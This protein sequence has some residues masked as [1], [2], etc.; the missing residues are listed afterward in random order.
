MAKKFVK[1]NAELNFFQRIYR[2]YWFILPISFIIVVLLT[3]KTW[4]EYYTMSSLE[5]EKS[6][7]L[8]E[9]KSVINQSKNDIALLKK[10]TNILDAFYDYKGSLINYE[11][12]FNTM[13]KYI[14]KKMERD[15]ISVEYKDWILSMNVW[16]KIKWYESYL[17]LLTLVDKC[18]FMSN[19]AKES[20]TGVNK[21]TFAW[22]WDSWE[23]MMSEE[24]NIKLNF[25]FDVLWKNKVLQLN[26]YKER[27]KEFL[28][29]WQL[30]YLFE[31][32]NWNT[33]DV[34]IENNDYLGKVFAIVD[35]KNN[36]R[37]NVWKVLWLDENSLYKE[38]TATHFVWKYKNEQDVAKFLIKYLQWYKEKLKN[39]SNVFKWEKDFF[40][41]TRDKDYKKIRYWLLS[42][43]NDPIIIDKEIKQIQTQI[44]QKQDEINHIKWNKWFIG[45]IFWGWDDNSIIEKYTNE[46]IELNKK[47]TDLNK[48]KI[49]IRK[50]ENGNVIETNYLQELVDSKIEK[51]NKEIYKLDLII[52]Y[53]DFLLNKN[54][55]GYDNYFNNF[56]KLKGN[57]PLER[58]KIIWDDGKER[59]ETIIEAK[60]RIEIE[61][62][63]IDEKTWQSIGY[64]I[65]VEEMSIDDI[66]EMTNMF[67]INDPKLKLFFYDE[68]K[69]LE[70]ENVENVLKNYKNE[71]DNFLKDIDKNKLDMLNL[72]KYKKNFYND[73]YEYNL[74]D[75]FSSILMEFKK[76]NF[77]SNFVK[78]INNPNYNFS[79]EKSSIKT[80]YKRR[81]F[82]TFENDINT[83]NQIDVFASKERF[84]KE[85]NKV[86]SFRNEINDLVLFNNWQFDCRKMDVKQEIRNIYNDVLNEKSNDSDK[87]KDIEKT[88]LLLDTMIIDMTL[89]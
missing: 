16:W 77:N 15:N 54:I 20:F 27:E 84:I 79:L 61:R 2:L 39:Y 42:W 11:L 1:K 70:Y 51:L 13:E 30:L 87:V 49:T 4:I 89:E 19:D 35:K 37:L 85:M 14:P 36:F 25:S 74:I 10:Y 81:L 83:S 33:N 52:R 48:N 72:E 28:T 82:L 23:T 59:L 40:I 86:E 34:Y 18:T 38:G 62:E 69:S 76:N 68:I 43:N 63:T 88:N 66:I 31:I 5:K 80:S 75:L 64:I 44:K 6:A 67:N 12:L 46:I 55:N 50:D 53:N 29:N 65:K 45:G 3:I 60:A 41:N 24:K 73:Y 58:K 78:E 56:S 32:V 21:I 71:F 26:Y 47:I 22:E 57:K 8:R 17:S 7:I 9:S